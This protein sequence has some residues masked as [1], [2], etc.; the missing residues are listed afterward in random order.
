MTDPFVAGDAGLRRV[1]WSGVRPCHGASG[2]LVIVQASD[3]VKLAG[4]VGLSSVMSALARSRPV[5]HSEADLQFAFAR[6]LFELAP[7]LQCRL[8]V[9]FRRETRRTEYLDL[10][11]SSKGQTSTAI[12]LKYF[13]RRWRGQAAGEM[14]DLRNHAAADLARLNFIH[15]VSRLERFARS[16]GH[17]G[18]ALMLTNDPGLWHQPKTGARRANFD[19]FR[20]HEDRELSGVLAWGNGYAP[21]RR[22]LV[23]TYRIHWHDYSEIQSDNPG[24]SLRWTAIRVPSVTAS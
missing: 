12:E 11:V 1:Y 6:Q 16:Y 24:G 18:I 13:T 9:P 15:D 23:N 14:F 21:N 17:E 10:L 7:Q 19:A 20:I 2:T 3:D 4:E 8:E 5:F 22:E